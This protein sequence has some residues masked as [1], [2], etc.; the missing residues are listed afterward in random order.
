[1]PSSKSN[2]SQFRYVGNLETKIRRT[3]INK[4][5]GALK[6]IRSV[7]DHCPSDLLVSAV[8]I[9]TLLSATSRMLYTMTVA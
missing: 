7:C 9:K 5:R 1:M 8:S 3:N 2:G 6:R 4:E